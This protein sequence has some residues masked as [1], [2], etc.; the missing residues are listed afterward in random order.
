LV[1]LRQA[2]VLRLAAGGQAPAARADLSARPGTDVDT[3]GGGGGGAWTRPRDSPPPPQLAGRLS[4]QRE[5]PRTAARATKRT[6]S[7]GREESRRARSADRLSTRSKR[8]PRPQGRGKAAMDCLAAYLAHSAPAEQRHMAAQL[9]DLAAQTRTPRPA[10]H[11]WM[12][13]RLAR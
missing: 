11:A 9:K 13:T 8:A 4:Q 10:S 5:N 3:P 1:P 2:Q 12:A 7:R 6:R